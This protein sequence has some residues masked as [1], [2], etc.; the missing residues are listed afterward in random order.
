[1]PGRRTLGRA[2]AALVGVEWLVVLLFGGLGLVFGPMAWIAAV[3]G[4]G[5]PRAAGVL[6]GLP[7]VV[8]VVAWIPL[9]FDS[10]A[11]L[12]LVDAAGILAILTLPAV[13]AA[14]LILAPR[15]EPPGAKA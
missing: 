2:L 12:S 1:M 3:V 13:L 9:V 14:A 10:T 5:R 11:R 8:L 4:G 15:P 7:V 6:L